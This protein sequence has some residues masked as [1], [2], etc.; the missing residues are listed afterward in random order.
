MSIA[1]KSALG[2]FEL[3]SRLRTVVMDHCGEDGRCCGWRV[4]VGMMEGLAALL[5]RV[6]LEADLHIT[7]DNPSISLQKFV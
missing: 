1:A 4:S 7:M 6:S 3:I 2:M 5:L